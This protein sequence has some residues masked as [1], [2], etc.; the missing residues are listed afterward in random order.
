MTSFPFAH[1]RA[2]FFYAVYKPDKNIRSKH[3]RA[4]ARQKR[5]SQTNHGQHRKAH[6]EV[7]E[8]LNHDY[9]ANAHQ[10]KATVVIS[11]AFGDCKNAYHHHRK[12]NNYYRPADKSKFL[13]YGSEHKVGVRCGQSLVIA[14]SHKTDAKPTAVLYALLGEQ[15]L[16]SLS[17][18]VKL[19]IEAH[20]YSLFLIICEKF[21]EQRKRQR[22]RRA[23]AEKIPA[24]Q[25]RDE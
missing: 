21:P 18:R 17:E 7:F 13:T 20:D 14:L 9:R 23:S 15:R 6:S 22:H 16:K 3:R 2:V 5:E 19:G 25:P 4:S 10:N 1:S 12:Q 11:A 8:R 24:R